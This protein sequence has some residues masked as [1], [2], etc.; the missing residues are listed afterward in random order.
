MEWGRKIREFVKQI[1]WI[2]LILLF[3]CSV[4]LIIV[5]LPQEK[6]ESFQ[7]KEE[8]L[9]YEGDE[10]DIYIE[11]MEERLSEILKLI[12]G[13]GKVE[14]MI[15]LA[16]SHETVV[17]KDQVYEEASEKEET[18][19]EKISKVRKEETIFSEKDNDL[20]PYIIKTLEPAIEGIIVVMEGGNNPSVI[21]EVRE[22]VQALF[23]VESH[24]IKVL[25]M[26]VLK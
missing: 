21:E 3:L 8:K 20:Y 26:E 14:V 16:S 15:T 11:K 9:V 17:N 25:K 24:K 6:E 18:G 13:A 5:N 1:G 19:K 23:H 12:E 22:A 4:F 7:N 2:R 10:N